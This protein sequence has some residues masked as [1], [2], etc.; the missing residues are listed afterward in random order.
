MTPTTTLSFNQPEMGGH[1]AGNDRHRLS[2]PTMATIYPLFKKLTTEKKRKKK[3]EIKGNQIQTK[4]T[5]KMCVYIYRFI[6]S[7]FH[8]RLEFKP[9]KK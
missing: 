3:V 8:F 5:E 6:G 1:C 9:K 2:P 7:S 4:E